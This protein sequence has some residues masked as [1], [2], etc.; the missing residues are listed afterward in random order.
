ML[1][2]KIDSQFTPGIP[3]AA[4]LP[5]CRTAGHLDINFGVFG[6]LMVFLDIH[7]IILRSYN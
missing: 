2:V 6:R 4:G 5:D 1:K 7:L 3:P